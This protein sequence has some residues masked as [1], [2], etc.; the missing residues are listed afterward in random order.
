MQLVL[1]SIIRFVIIS[2]RK[3]LMLQPKKIPKSLKKSEGKVYLK[4][5]K[6]N[7]EK[8]QPKKQAVRSKMING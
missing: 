5:L 3:M 7:M 6:T 2:V 8:R 4:S 1:G